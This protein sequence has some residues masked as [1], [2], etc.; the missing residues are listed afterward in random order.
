MLCE[1]EFAFRL[2]NENK[3]LLRGAHFFK[4]KKRKENF[5]KNRAE[6]EG[7][8]GRGGGK[9]DIDRNMWLQREILCALQLLVWMGTRW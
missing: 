7:R 8:G 9:A 1:L 2:V 6:G 3:L 4:D 5:L